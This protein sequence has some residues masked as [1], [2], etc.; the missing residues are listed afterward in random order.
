[1]SR[2][3]SKNTS[4][5]LRT[6]KLANGKLSYYLDYYDSEG[7]RIRES[8]NLYATNNPKNADEKRVNKEAKELAIKLHTAKKDEMYSGKLEY[9]KKN[10][11]NVYFLDYFMSYIDSQKF[12]ESNHSVWLCTY[13]ALQKICDDKVLLKNINHYPF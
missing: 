10:T 3:N 1:M 6:R 5:A 13:K 12:K 9:N 4:V 2:I 11:G 8:L 7:N